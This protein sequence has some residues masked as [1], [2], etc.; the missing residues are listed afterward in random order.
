MVL[1][2]DGIGLNRV[3]YRAPV[4][5]VLMKNTVVFFDLPKDQSIYRG[6]GRSRWR[7]GVVGRG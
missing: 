5:T 4:S 3:K 1:K 2:V 7:Q 6:R